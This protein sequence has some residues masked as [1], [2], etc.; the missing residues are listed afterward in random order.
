MI[1]EINTNQNLLIAK[2]K[3]DEQKV[4]KEIEVKED[5]S[6]QEFEE[7]VSKSFF[8]RRPNCVK[9]MN[10]DESCQTLFGRAACLPRRSCSVFLLTS[11]CKLFASDFFQME[12]FLARYKI[13]LKK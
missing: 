5:L 11:R 2:S 7:F 12:I 8:N 10:S 1:N 3:A 4:E 13:L 6:Q 9:M